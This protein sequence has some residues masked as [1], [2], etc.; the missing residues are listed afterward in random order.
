MTV[1]KDIVTHHTETLLQTRTANLKIEF[2][3]E[4]QNFNVL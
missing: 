1:S 2:E 4:N 3:F